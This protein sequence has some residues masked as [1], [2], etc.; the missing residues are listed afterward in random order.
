MAALTRYSNSEL[1]NLPDCGGLLENGKCKWLSVQKCTGAKC[2]YY[3]KINSLAKAQERLRSLD[4]AAQERIALK[5]YGGYR[6]WMDAE[7]KSRR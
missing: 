3:H 6:P 1:L 5:Y 7:T 4:E 2:P